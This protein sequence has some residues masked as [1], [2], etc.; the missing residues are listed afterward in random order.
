MFSSIISNKFKKMIKSTTLLFGLFVFLIFSVSS[1]TFTN[2]TGQAYNTWNSNNAWATALSRTIV[3]SGL[4]NPLSA[5]GTVLKQVNLKLGDGTSVNLTS[6]AIRLTSPLGTP[7]SIISGNFNATLAKNVDIKFR[8]DNILQFPSSSNQDPY[9][10]GYYRTTLANS[11]S[12][13]NGENPNGN[14]V[15]EI[16]ENTLSEI[17]FVSVELVFGTSI[18]VND[19]SATT[20][21]DDCSSPQCMGE[22][23]VI[24]ATV[25]GYSGNAN[26]PNILAPY[27]GGCNWNGAHNNSAWFVF[28]PTSSTAKI[29]ISGIT[30]TIQTLIVD[31]LNA[32]VSGNQTVP[33]G[34]CPVDA[35]NDTYTSPR[36]TPSSG[37]SANQQFN[38]SGLI[39]GNKYFL[40][41]DGNGGLIS[42]LYIELTGGLVDLCCPTVI[43]GS[44]D[45]CAGSASTLYSQ[46]GG[47]VGGTWSV[48]PA[49]A[50]TIVSTSGSFTPSNTLSTISAT[51]SYDDG[52]CVKTF[53]ITVHAVS[54]AGSVTS[55]P[56]CALATGTVTVTSVGVGITYTLT[57]T[58]PVVAPVSNGTGI[59]SGLSP[60]NYDVTSSANGCSST[61]LSLIVN[62]QPVTPPIPT[63]VL[64]QPTCS[65]STGSITASSAGATSFEL[66]GLVPAVAMTSNG[67]G[68]FT[69]LN[70][71]T[72]EVI[73]LA[74]GCS[75]A[76]FAFT[77]NAQ[78]LTP[79][80]PTGVLVQPTCSV[81]TGSITAS[82]AGATSF[83]LTGLVP[84]VAM[85]SNGTGIFTNLN[86]GTYE[87]IALANGC[88][89]AA[90]AFTI[91]AQ[92][93][94]PSAPV[95]SFK[96]YF[97]STSAKTIG[98]INVTGTNIK[99]YDATTSGT[100]LNP[101]D[102]LIDGAHYYATQTVGLCESISYLDVLVY[103]DFLQLGL[104]SQTSSIC[105]KQTGSATVLAKNGI[106]SYNYIWSNSQVGNIN[107]NIGS[108]DYSVTVT[109]SI[110]CSKTLG[111]T[112]S[113]EYLIPE[114]ITP[115]GDGKNDTWIINVDSK[116]LVQL[117][118]RW[119]NLIY[120]AIPY[121]DD[122]EGK[123]NEGALLGNDYLPNGTYFYVIDYKNGTDPVSGYI[124]LIR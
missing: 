105:G 81:S 121:L 29:T 110:G 67:T 17:A 8:D 80:T 34:G 27:P 5:G 119:G 101:S 115:N 95:G 122:W 4:S 69:N 3:V 85:T 6:Y 92:P 21:N 106:G 47:T 90:F 15:I 76:A 100:L 114:I 88:I 12:T 59:F 82:S 10:I 61:V 48:S 116:V 53:P 52:S 86:P 113:C 78:P 62:A 118:N 79:P 35:V 98:D 20:L 31:E 24:K 51:I 75:S 97:C 43:S 1:Q 19:V 32:C 94:T 37:S 54:I 46:V 84:A 42:P 91:N 44:T 28:E 50:G 117:Y 65:V 55:Q 102:L 63:G 112:I 99:W 70:P 71:G 73:A 74:N 93:T 87:V 123:S 66:T 72:Y 96:Q 30:N 60:G 41:V 40:V 58:A 89:S 111:V 7:I 120:T 13:F 104:T 57:G 36:Y 109:D 9:N 26:D 77:I 2:N 33:N 18:V 11:F 16:V 25:S 108:G 68:I 23:S 38:L 83:E 39:P 45:V 124:E 22:S 49:S 64:V 103:L 14:W 56:T 107:N